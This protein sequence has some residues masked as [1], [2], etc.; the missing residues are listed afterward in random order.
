MLRLAGN[1]STL[2]HFS[3]K[4]EAQV[5]NSDNTIQV[6]PLSPKTEFDSKLINKGGEE[7]GLRQFHFHVPSEHTIEEKGFPLELHLVFKNAATSQLAVLG[8]FF[9][10]SVGV[11][12]GGDEVDGRSSCHEFFSS[13]VALVKTLCLV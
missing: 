5:K 13:I 7:F 4:E 2:F 6:L 10:F 11:G 12:S 8:V 9:D 1:S 3:G